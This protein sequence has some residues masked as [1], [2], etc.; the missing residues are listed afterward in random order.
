MEVQA[1][2]AWNTQSK[3]TAQPTSLQLGGGWLLSEPTGCLHQDSSEQLTL[4]TSAP[5]QP[6]Q[7]DL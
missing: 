5:F 1:L 6:E 4:G 2:R 7:K 3:A